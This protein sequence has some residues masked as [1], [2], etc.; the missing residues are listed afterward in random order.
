MPL[1][2]VFFPH[3]LD[4][5][6]FSILALP[7][8]SVFFGWL[9][10]KQRI[11]GAFF[12]SGQDI[13]VEANPY[14]TTIVAPVNLLSLRALTELCKLHGIDTTDLDEIIK[15]TD[16]KFKMRRNVFHERQ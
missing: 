16:E 9:H 3:F 8:L 1:F 13:Q 6:V 7:F 15:M 14:A 12:S 2:S 4:F 5:I 10:F 11:F